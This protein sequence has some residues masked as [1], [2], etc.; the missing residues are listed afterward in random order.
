MPPR[1]VLAAMIACESK[2]VSPAQKSAAQTQIKVDVMGTSPADCETQMADRQPF[3]RSPESRHD[4]VYCTLK[5]DV[6]HHT[7]VMISRASAELNS[8]AFSDLRTLRIT[9]LG[10]SL[11]SSR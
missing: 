5:I 6:K 1:D 9:L 8:L 11:Q 3:L 7:V 10:R 2:K 4:I